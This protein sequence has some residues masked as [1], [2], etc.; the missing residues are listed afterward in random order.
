VKHS[1]TRYRITLE[2]YRVGLPE[3]RA[4]QDEK[5]LGGRWL[6]AAQ[7]ERLAFTSAHGRVLRRLRQDD[8]V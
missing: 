8:S 4:G 1:I 7:L 5:R 6:T 3:S 2:T